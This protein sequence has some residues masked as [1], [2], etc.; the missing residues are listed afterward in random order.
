MEDRRGIDKKKKKIGVGM[1]SLP[2]HPRAPGSY[3]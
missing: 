2:L 1:L 3:F